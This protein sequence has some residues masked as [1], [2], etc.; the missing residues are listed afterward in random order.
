MTDKIIRRFQIKGII[1]D[2]SKFVQ[3]RE[4]FYKEIVATMK[5]NGYVPLLDLD[6]VWITEY[7]HA[8]K[9]YNCVY[10]WQGEYVGE[11]AWDYE[12]K[13]GQRLLPTRRTK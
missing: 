7:N 9:N 11:N 10:T 13:A 8:E 1:A 5:D 2:D 3:L 4:T 12:G 6:P